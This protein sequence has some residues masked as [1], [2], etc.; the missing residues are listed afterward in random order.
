M[1]A[2]IARIKERIGDIEDKMMEKKELE[3]Q[4]NNYCIIRGEFER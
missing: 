1:E 4:R 3:K 2:L